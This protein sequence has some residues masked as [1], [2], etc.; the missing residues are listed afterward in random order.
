MT[1]RT[2]RKPRCRIRRMTVADIP[3][4]AE[5]EAEVWGEGAATPEMLAARLRNCPE[6]NLLAIADSGSLQGYVSFC[7]IDYQEFRE[8]GRITWYDLSADGTAATHRDDGPDLFGINLSVLRTAHA[9]VSSRL[10]EAVILYGMSRVCRRGLLGARLPG[11]HKRAQEMNAQEYAFATRASGR[12]L[13]PEVAIYV[14]AG[15]RPLEVVEGY[16]RD[17][18]SLDWGLVMEKANPLPRGFRHVG[19]ATI[20]VLRRLD[21]TNTSRG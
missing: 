15:L 18:E 6:G 21:G 1:P 9:G 4:V 20:R 12:P 16:F 10:L 14:R 3:P 13:D 8:A 2:G 7:L 11:Y 17:P 19:A 5:L